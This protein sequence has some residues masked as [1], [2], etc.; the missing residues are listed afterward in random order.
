MIGY[1][2]DEVRLTHVEQP[3]GYTSE[4]DNDCPQVDWK[5]TDYEQVNQIFRGKAFV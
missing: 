5:G 2:A 1:T 3:R 4:H